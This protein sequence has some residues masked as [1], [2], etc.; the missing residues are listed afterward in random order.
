MGSETEELEEIASREYK[1]GFVTD[2]D[3]DSAPP[4]LDE[5][6]IAFISN[7]KEEPDWILRCV[8]NR[9]KFKGRLNCND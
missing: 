5:D 9:A 7:K 1:Y 8:W 2:I 4:G 6:I 3:Q